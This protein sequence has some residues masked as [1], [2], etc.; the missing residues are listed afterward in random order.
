MLVQTRESHRAER[1]GGK[2]TGGAIAEEVT[3]VVVVAPDGGSVGGR[4][5][6]AAVCTP[7]AAGEDVVVE[8]E[9]RKAKTFQCGA[10]FGSVLPVEAGKNVAS[11][12]GSRIGGWEH[13]ARRGWNQGCRGQKGAMTVAWAPED[14]KRRTTRERRAK[15]GFIQLLSDVQSWENASEASAPSS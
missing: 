13:S 9:T 5:D 14:A 8:P 1:V 3:Q 11:A 7:G 15:G 2:A 10:P 12:F 4:V 6:G